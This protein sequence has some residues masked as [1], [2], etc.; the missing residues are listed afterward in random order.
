[1]SRHLHTNRR[2][3]DVA[4]AES[5]TEAV[6]APPA[7]TF[8][9]VSVTYRWGGETTTALTDFNLRIAT[10]EAT[11]LLGPSG[12]G[13]ST[14]LK[15][16]AGAVRPV[17]GRILVGDRDVTTIAPV[18]R[19]VGVAVRSDGL[20]PHL[21]VAD[22]V[23]LGLAGR[24]RRR[25]Q[26][27]SAVSAALDAVAMGECP[28][29]FPREFSPVQ[30][31]RI[32]VARA[33]VAN[34]AIVLFD[35]PLTALGPRLH[36]PMLAELRQLQTSLP[37]ITMLYATNDPE[38]A[39]ALADRIAVLRDTRLVDVDSAAGLWE[40]PP[41]RFT[42]EYL[43]GANVVGV[44]VGRV[45]GNS[46][47]VVLGDR[48]LSALAYPASTGARRWAPQSAAYLCIRP[49]DV[50]V[51]PANEPGALPARVRATMWRGN[52]TRLTLVVDGIDELMYADVVGHARY[53]IDAQVG[54]TLPPQACVLI[55]READAAAS[56]CQSRD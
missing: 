7:A 27:R 39:L 35:E 50:D 54:V 38:Q 28:H 24:R 26:V 10:G 30:R 31:Q 5:V 3:L 6:S 55:G 11:A 13:K 18:G 44:T 4:A 53:Q 52:H 46:A 34:P 2:G 17:P 49:H 9:S 25:A 51:C 15:V 22:N 47:L 32:A 14:A 29:R 16:L 1:M 12:A 21:T 8:S 48:M 37:Q 41:S 20:M 56:G 23:A 42:A 33:I 45:Y 40:R 43:C 36:A 19:R